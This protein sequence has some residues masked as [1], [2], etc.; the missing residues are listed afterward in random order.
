MNKVHTSR[1]KEAAANAA[2][3][4][5][6]IRKENTGDNPLRRGRYCLIYLHLT[7]T[8]KIGGAHS[9]PSKKLVLK[10][11]AKRPPMLVKFLDIKNVST[12]KLGE[13]TVIIYPEVGKI[14]L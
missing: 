14:S 8:L 5:T 12:L 7:I 3:D 2:T 4:I 11:L 13:T 10:S 1:E 6:E 9:P